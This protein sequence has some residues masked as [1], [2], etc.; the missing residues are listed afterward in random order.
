MIIVHYKSKKE[1]R[2]QIGSRL[3]YQET[4]LFGD[5][6]KAMAIHCVEQTTDHWSWWT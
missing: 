4:S 1:M 3:K 2:E 5:E 6:F